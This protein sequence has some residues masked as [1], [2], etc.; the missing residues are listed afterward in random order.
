MAK[1]SE[2]KVEQDID[3][4]R[5]DETLRFSWE[6]QFSALKPGQV[7]EFEG[8]DFAKVRSRA[9]AYTNKTEIVLEVGRKGGVCIVRLAGKAKAA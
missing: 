6:S 7:L 1:K 8:H 4:T 3:F 5:T 2:T 9:L